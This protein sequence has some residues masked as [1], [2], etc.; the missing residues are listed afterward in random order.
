MVDIL[1]YI[2]ENLSWVASIV[3]LGIGISLILTPAAQAE[4]TFYS[5]VSAEVNYCNSNQLSQ[6]TLQ[7]VEEKLNA[8]SSR[9]EELYVKSNIGNRIEYVIYNTDE[10][11]ITSTNSNT[12]ERKTLER[13]NSC[14]LFTSC[15]SFYFSNQEEEEDVQYQI[16]ILP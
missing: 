12:P 8:L 6:P 2:V 3:V 5:Y 14:L 11:T 10:D 9:Y 4:D 7:C 15:I 16:V 1:N 13:M